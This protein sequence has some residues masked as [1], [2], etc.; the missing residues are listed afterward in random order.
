MI[1]RFRDVWFKYPFSTDWILRGLDLTIRKNTFAVVGLNGS[2]KTTLLRLIMG[3]EKPIR[4]EILFNGRVPN[5]DELQKIFYYIPVNVRNVL[6]GPTVFD[7][8]RKSVESSQGY[9][10]K[11]FINEVIDA[12]G[13][14]HLRNR[15]II[16]LSEGERRLVAII[17]AIIS[18]KKIIVLDEP[19]IGLDKK[20]REKIFSLI[21]EK[22]T[23][24]IFIAATND[25]RFAVGFEEIALIHNGVITKQGSPR[26][27]LYDIE[28]Y[29]SDIYYFSNQVIQFSKLF[30][31]RFNRKIEDPVTKTELIR[32]LRKLF[33]V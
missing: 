9:V 1:I 19:T 11:G 27:V 29:D 28:A 25:P 24:R 22:S 14:D 2:G 30:K 23:N 33:R 15:K 31:K 18:G 12:A 5:R 20:Y 8:L 10:N 26:E 16:F 17:S 3:L 32:E 13:I 7:E 21:K 6:V 4:G